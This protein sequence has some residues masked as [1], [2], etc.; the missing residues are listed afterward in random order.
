MS[1]RAR[2]ALLATLAV[3]AGVYALTPSNVPTLEAG[4]GPAPR[5][6][7][8]EKPPAPE[9]AFIQ[10]VYRN[11]ATGHGPHCVRLP[12]RRPAGDDG[13]RDVTSAK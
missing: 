4:L 9:P 7:P 8:P 12:S 6:C 13:R 1:R 11:E 5:F 10:L 3:G 2:F